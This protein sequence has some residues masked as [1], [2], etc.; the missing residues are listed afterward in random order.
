[1]S[2]LL[3]GTIEMCRFY[4]FY[5]LRSASLNPFWR[6]NIIMQ[7][8][9]YLTKTLFLTLLACLGMYSTSAS[10]SLSTKAATPYQLKREAPQQANASQKVLSAY[11][12]WVGTRYRMGGTTKA[13]IDCSAF[14]KATMSSAF[15]VHLPRS[16]AEQRH[17]GRAISKSE[18]RPGDLVFF[19]NNNHVGVYV[20]GGKFVHAGSSTGVTMA[21]LSDRYWAKTYTQS[22]RVM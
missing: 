1:M 11:R 13:G 18:L 22:R 2:D 9:S 21:S 10:A 8:F 3:L 15:N 19:R 16:T 5:N 6:D 17:L 20:G 7:K 14:V 12:Q 4:C